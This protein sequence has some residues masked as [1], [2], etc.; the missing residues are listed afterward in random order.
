MIA[1][2]SR[3]VIVAL[4]LSLAACSS[5]QQNAPPAQDAAR[6]QAAAN[7]AKSK[8]QLDMYEK[9]RSAGNLELAA[10]IGEQ[11]VQ[12]F[13]G[14]DAATQVQKTLAE[15]QAAAKEAGAKRRLAALWLY[16]SGMMEGGAQN[17]ATIKPSVP[18]SGAGVQLILRRHADWGQ[19][20]YLY[21]TAP[22]FSCANPC[23]VGVRFDDTPQRLRASLPPTGEPAMFIEDDTIFLQKMQKAKTV[24]IEA[25]PKGKSDAYDLGYKYDDA[26]N[27]LSITDKPDGGQPAEA[28]CFSYDHVQR[29]TAAWTPKSLDCATAPT[30]TGL[31]GPASYWHEYSYDPVGNGN[32]KIEMLHGTTDTKRTYI[33]PAQGGAPGTMPHAVTQVTTSAGATNTVQKTENYAYD[34]TGNTTCRPAT[35]AGNICPTTGN[36]GS[37]SQTLTWNEEGKL[38]KSTD[39]T[40]DT[41][42]LYDADGNRLIRR[43]PTGTTLYLQGGTELRKPKNGAAIATRYYSA[44]GNT[45]AVRTAAGV[46]W[47]VNDRHGTTSATI[48]NDTKQTLN[49]QRTLPFGGNRGANPTTWAGDKGFVGGTK[50]NTG[51]T[52]LGAREYDPGLGKFISV[53]PLMDLADPTQW[54]AYAYANNSPT[55]LTDPAGTW[56]KN[57]DIDD[58]FGH[59]NPGTGKYKNRTPNLGGNNG[60]EGTPDLGDTPVN[61]PDGLKQVL[62]DWG[63]DSKVYTIRSLAEFAAKGD[64][65]WQL[66]CGW[67]ADNVVDECSG[68]NPFT[69]RG[70]MKERLLESGIMVLAVTGTLACGFAIEVCVGLALEAAAGEGSFAATGSMVGATGFTTGIG[71]MRTLLGDACSFSQD[72]KVLMADGSTKPFKDLKVGDVVLAADPQTGEQAPKTI[73]EVW[74]HSDDLYAITIN[75]KQ[76]VTTEDHPF[77]NETDQTWEGAEELHSGDL[78]RTPTGVARV[79]G[80]DK[81][82]HRHASAYNLTVADLHTY[83]VLAGTTPVLV[84]NTGCGVSVAR[85][86]EMAGM[87]RDAVRQKG[88]SGIGAG[89][90]AEAD[91]MG[92]AWVGPNYKVASDGRT[93]ISQDGLRQYRPPSFKPNRPERFGGPG[94][95]AN[96]EW[97]VQPK[98]QWQADA[99][100]NILD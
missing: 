16:Q 80:F 32:R 55:T 83:Y 77:W 9:L 92:S 28:Q 5:S 56:P 98:G 20:V 60:S 30:V 25:T 75:G 29:L 99:H 50:D 27:L 49:R 73:E 79:N 96:F 54:N 76:L 89:T 38:A 59:E 41:T 31:G 71:G 62:P 66:V 51:L 95:Q 10:S 52:H 97:R 100:L 67:L 42:Y 64:Q 15:A 6:A 53:D 7:A 3:F 26:G 4:A 23:T 37:N 45:V 46:T 18:S 44:A 39:S 43:D 84:H 91:M 69:E 94:Y 11:I 22:G 35:T 21:G 88:F 85:E 78:V 14:S 72:T 90:R 19:S 93:M 1:S 34:K 57:P 58:Q 74:T 40:G 65:Y 12:K 47:T 2:V 63:Y 61:V 87:L 33:Y 17:T 13:P 70:T 36:A 86:M 48:S 82:N 68:S 24:T 81:A 8:E